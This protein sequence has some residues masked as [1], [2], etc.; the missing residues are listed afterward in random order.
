MEII[1]NSHSLG[2]SNY[3]FQFTPKYRK[4]IFRNCKI[5]N[6][7]RAALEYKAHMLR[8]TI[9]AM[10]FGPDHVHLFVTNCKKYSVSQLAQYFK[11][12]SSY[13]V[14]KHLPYD[15]MQYNNGPSFWSDGLFYESIGC[16]T[17]DMVTFYIERQ[18]KKHWI[19]QRSD[20]PSRMNLVVQT[21]LDSFLMIPRSLLRL[22]GSLF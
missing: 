9:E 14:R 12:Y 3:H 1:R 2:G 22:G 6:L 10:E 13:I 11:G 7:V 17:S 20:L 5:R 8:I 16:V 15:V 19:R 18:Q 21:D 4:S